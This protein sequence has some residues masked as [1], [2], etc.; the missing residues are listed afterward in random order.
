VSAAEDTTACGN[1]GHEIPSGN[2]VS[3]SVFCYR[4]NYRCIACEEVIPLRDKESHIAQWTDGARLLDATWRRDKDTVQRMAAHDMDFTRAKHPESQDTVL[5]AAAYMGDIELIS[6]FMGFG[7]EVD[8]LNA[9]G[10][11]PLHM[12]AEQARMASV[13]LL[14]ELGADLNGRSGNGETPLML[15]CRKGNAEAAKFLLEMRADPEAC[16]KLGDTPLQLAQ[17]LGFQEV[18]L[19]L[20]SAGAPLRPGTP[21]RARSGSPMPPRPGSGGG[22]PRSGKVPDSSP[23]LAG[24]LGMATGFGAG[25]GYPPNIPRKG[26]PPAPSP[27]RA[28][29][30][31]P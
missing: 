12:A 22:S 31:P 25:A 24:A 7:V 15:V 19:A 21:N 18:V 30:R 16:T 3:H 14:V 17:R 26:A 1:C 2:L 10:C 6:F 29:P 9:Q 5:H 8:P 27:P 11:T 28:V 4:N 13:K 23:R 20:C